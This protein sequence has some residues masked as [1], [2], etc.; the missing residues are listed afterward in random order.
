M[1]DKGIHNIFI[2]HYH[3]DVEELGKLKELLQSRGHEM[4][5]S[6][7]DG[8]EPN[9]AKDP[10][11]IKS[12]IRPKIDWAGTTVVLIG[13]E[14]HTRSWVNWE[15]EYANKLGKRI[16]GVYVRGAKESDVP[17]N[18]NMFGDSLVGWDSDKIIGAIEG[19]H[20]D[21]LTPEGTPRKGVWPVDRSNC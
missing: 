15:I 9:Q 17:K 12:L 5:D 2:S 8:S 10:D 16:V 21:W 1:E 19:K 11:Y 4:R 3:K 13:P 7:I 20:T 6:S 18:L 14:T